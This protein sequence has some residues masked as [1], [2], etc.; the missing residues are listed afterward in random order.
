MFAL[1]NADLEQRILGCSD[2]PANFNARLTQQGGRVVSV[3]PLY[4]H[5]AE[6][7]RARIR[8]TFDV[9]LQ[10]TRENQDEFVWDHI[11]D[12]DALGRIRMEA[13]D[14]F[15]ADYE[16]GRSEQRYRA[17]SLPELDLADNTFDLAL[18]SHFLFL[19]SQQLELDFHINAINEL[20]RVATEV[21]IFPLL[22]LGATPSP[23]VDPVCQHLKK[24]GFTVTQERVPYEFQ[25]GGNQMLRIRT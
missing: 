2:G 14:G 18:C 21:R 9:V 23:H 16:T 11:P 3:D 17:Q 25:R 13:M 7:I 22:Q 6:F 4:T 12:P 15:L 5:D 10:Q 20:C 1:S 19:Y 8:E 24:T